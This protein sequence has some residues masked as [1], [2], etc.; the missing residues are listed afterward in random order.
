MISVQIPYLTVKILSAD[1]Y[2]TWVQRFIFVICWI[3]PFEILDSKTDA[4]SLNTL[5]QKYGVRRAKL[6]GMILVIP[7]MIME[8]L[9]VN[10]SFAVLPIAV[11][12]VL[13]IHFSSV[14]R[15]QYYTSFWVESVPVL[16]WMLLLLV[17]GFNFLK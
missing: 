15:S 12:M 7:F 14:K 6:F 3:I 1:Y 9:K 10:Y 8:F 2:V 5:P 4:V 13:F 16:W 17:K 11:I